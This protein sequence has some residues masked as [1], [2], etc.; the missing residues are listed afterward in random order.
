M[1]SDAGQQIVKL[2]SVSVEGPADATPLVIAHGLFGSGRNF[3][4][5]ARRYAEARPVASVDLR[6]HGDSPWTP[7][8]DYVAM[9]TDLARFAAETFGRPVCLLGHSMGGKAAMAAALRAPDQVAAL[10]VADIAP[11]AY[12]HSHEAFVEAMRGVDLSRVARR[13][14]A[15]AMLADAIPEAPLRAFILQNLVVENGRARWRLNLDAIGAEM[16]NLLTWPDA[17]AGRRYDGPT[18][19]YRGGASDYAPDTA[20][21]AIEATF[22]KVEIATMEGAGHWLHAERPAEFYELTS[23]WIQRTL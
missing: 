21:S 14:D 6:N 3:G 1:S 2:S 7:E 11:I 4:T 23:G 10:I 22:P 20:R 19:F 17:L 8:M 15:D 13:S 5:L 18:L 12:A 16:P 9:G